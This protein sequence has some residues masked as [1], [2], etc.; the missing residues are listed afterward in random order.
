MM[1]LLCA[2]SA[3]KRQNWGEMSKQGTATVQKAFFTCGF[4]FQLNG[5]QGET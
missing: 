5:N 3:T 2:V 4:K 1:T